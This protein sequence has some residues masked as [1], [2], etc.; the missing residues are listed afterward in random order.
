MKNQDLCMEFSQE[1][2]CFS[3]IVLWKY[4][5]V[6]SSVVFVPLSS[7]CAISL[8]SSSL[9]AVS[10][11]GWFCHPAILPRN[12]QDQTSL[13][14][15]CTIV[16]YFVAYELFLIEWSVLDSLVFRWRLFQGVTK[17]CRRIGFTAQRTCSH[18]G[19]YSGATK[20]TSHSVLQGI[21]SD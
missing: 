11:H 5:L 17:V 12:C 7:Y 20:S 6:T 9:I 2:Y 10:R 14:Y 21:F 18:R 4:L 3:L 13:V 1:Q 19:S 8:L 16:I 15:L